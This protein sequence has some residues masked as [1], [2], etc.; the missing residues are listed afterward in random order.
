[1]YIIYQPQDDNF[2][3]NVW[4]DVNDF[5][6]GDENKLDWF[7]TKEN[8]PNAVELGRYNISLLL[9]E[10][11][12]EKVCYVTAHTLSQVFEMTNLWNDERR[13]RKVHPRC[14]STSVGDIIHKTYGKNGEWYMVNS[15][16]FIRLA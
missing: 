14:M 4:F 16:G 8:R 11:K 2:R 1:M 9:N 12:Y 13:V 3:R 15:A 6:S 7:S 5:N 10:G